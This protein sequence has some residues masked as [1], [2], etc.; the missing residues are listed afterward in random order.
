MSCVT[1]ICLFHFFRIWQTLLLA[2]TLKGGRLFHFKR[3][4]RNYAVRST[5]LN[6]AS[7]P[8]LLIISKP[9]YASLWWK[10]HS[11]KAKNKCAKE[12][13]LK[14][15]SKHYFYHIMMNASTMKLPII[16]S[17]RQPLSFGCVGHI[18]AEESFKVKLCVNL[19]LPRDLKT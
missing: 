9:I 16:Y 3:M 17:Y 15:L 4:K 8:K 13:C 1:L 19:L 2:M 12:L 10:T 7:A 11:E 5:Y 18:N 6:C 14:C